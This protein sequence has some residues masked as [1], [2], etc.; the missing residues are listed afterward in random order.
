MNDFNAGDKVKAFV[1]GADDTVIRGTLVQFEAALL[2][3]R[4][5]WTIQTL[6]DSGFTIEILERA[7]V[8]F[9]I[10]E[11]ATILLDRDGDVWRLATSIGWYCISETMTLRG[12]KSVLDDFGPFAVLRPEAETALAL[13]ADLRAMCQEIAAIPSEEPLTMDT[14]YVLIDTV[15]EKSTR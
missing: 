6:L 4:S 3:G 15:L 14:M 12:G 11:G 7:P 1:K 8:A 13:C 10:P 2:V 9:P 5:G